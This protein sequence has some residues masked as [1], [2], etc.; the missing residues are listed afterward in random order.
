[1]VRSKNKKILLS[2][3]FLIPFV[4]GGF[5]PNETMMP[6]FR[7]KKIVLDAGHGGKDPGNLGSNSKEKDI[8]LAVTLLVGKYIKE[9][10]PDVEVIYTRK[11]DSF[12]A[13]K[14]RPQIANNNKADLFVS[15]HSNSAPSKSA[16]GTETFVMGM[17]YFDD[18]FDIVKKENSVILLEDN[19][20]EKYEGFDPTS[21]ESYIMFNLMSKA[22]FQ[23]SVSLADN[24]E[25]QFKNRVGRNSRGV[26]QG[27]F[28]V[29]WTPSMP[30]VLIELGFLSNTNEE[31]FL[32]SKA[33]Q[34]YM[35]S[36]IYRSIRDYKNEIEG[37]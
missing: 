18:N 15:I 36:A 21:P 29:L 25:S 9:N 17:K 1:M 12:P 28:Y 24:I 3:I 32:M 35:A 27:P 14:D 20:Q 37:N 10:L 6:A 22:Y 8:N 4:F 2:L 23:N 30:S 13:L 19:Y 31:K 33:G 7:M 34:E 16:Y 11:D 26:K 5:I